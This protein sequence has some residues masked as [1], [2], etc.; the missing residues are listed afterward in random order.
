MKGKYE[1]VFDRPIE[2]KNAGTITRMMVGKYVRVLYRNMEGF[3][4]EYFIETRKD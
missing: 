3:I 2:C 4:Q 1:G